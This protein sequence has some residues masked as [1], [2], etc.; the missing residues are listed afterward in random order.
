MLLIGRICRFF[1]QQCND[2]RFRASAADPLAVQAVEP[3]S[4]W[5]LLLDTIMVLHHC[6]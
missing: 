5:A 4:G 6:I 2:Q 1:R 3:C